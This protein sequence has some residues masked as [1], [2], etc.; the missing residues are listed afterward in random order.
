VGEAE[1]EGERRYLAEV[2]MRL[3][4]TAEDVEAALEEASSRAL[5][6]IPAAVEEV[7]HVKVGT[8]YHPLYNLCPAPASPFLA[9]TFSYLISFW[10]CLN[11]NAC[12]APASPFLANTFSYLI[13]FRYGLNLNACMAPASPF[14][15]NTF[16]YLIS[17]RYCLNL[18]ACMFPASPFLAS[19]LHQ[20]PIS[21]APPPPLRSV[22][23]GGWWWREGTGVGCG[24]EGEAASGPYL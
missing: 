1:G 19:Q 22:E 23:R 17:F 18:N 2:E 15:A 16:S 11:L 6:R 8:R 3:H 4:L 5:L 14:L 20:L 9:N 21:T 7:A 24:G 13:S 10:Y 12:M